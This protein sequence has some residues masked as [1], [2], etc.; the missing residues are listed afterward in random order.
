[1]SDPQLANDAEL[2]A[3]AVRG[4]LARSDER[5]K[6]LLERRRDWVAALDE[7][8]D[9]ASAG[10]PDGL[11]ALA[12]AGETAADRE[13]MR[14]IVA[15][16]VSGSGGARARPRRLLPLLLAAALLAA[17]GVGWWLRRS[18]PAAPR[19]PFLGG[20]GIAWVAPVDTVEAWGPFEWAAELP[21][22]GTFTL[23]VRGEDPAAAPLERVEGL[24][25]PRWTPDPA[26]ASAWPE[27]IEVI[28]EV[29]DPL[30]GAIGARAVRLRRSPQ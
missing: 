28:V 19:G 15:R 21:P 10:A 4:E 11:K 7:L 25:E 3:R 17:L 12:R 14:A 16:A 20:Q 23:T 26:T 24:R 5:L 2:F 18:P 22:R 13:R 27:V 8:A 30:N 6:E 9:G 1:M 29:I